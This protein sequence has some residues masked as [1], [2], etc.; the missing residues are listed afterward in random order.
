MDTWHVE[1]IL[2]RPARVAGAILGFG[3]ASLSLRLTAMRHTIERDYPVAVALDIVNREAADGLAPD[4]TDMIHALLH[5]AVLNAARHADAALVRVTVQVNGGVVLLTISDDGK[6]FPFSGTYDLRALESLDVGPRRITFGV[7]AQHGSLTL[8][9]RSSGSRLDI[10]LPR[11]AQSPAIVR[12]V[13]AV[14]A[15]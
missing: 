12:D 3:A 7:A 14:A 10:V 5:E 9:S 2:D 6:G 13:P 15:E 4:L 1:P 11:D 8:D